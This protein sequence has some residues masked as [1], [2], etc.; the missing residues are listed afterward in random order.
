[1]FATRINVRRPAGIAFFFLLISLFAFAVTSKAWAQTPPSQPE[2]SAEVAGATVQQEQS[3]DIVGGR[4]AAPGAWPWQVALVSHNS[5][6][7]YYGQ[8]CGGSL[9]APDWVLTAAHCLEGT[10]AS[11][12]D[13]MVGVHRLTESWPR[14]QADRVL[15]HPDRSEFTLDGDVALLHLSMPVTQTTIALFTAGA[16][17]SELDYLRGTV[18]GWGNMDPNSWFGEF[19]DALQ[20]VAL[21]LIGWENCRQIWGDAISD[22]QICA[23]YPIMN[24]STCSGDSG[25]PLMV[26]KTNGQWLQVGIVEAGPYPCA[27]AEYPDIFTRISAYGSWIEGCMQNPDDITCTGADSY[28]PDDTAPA[29]HLY[30]SFGITETHSFHQA[31]DQDWLRFAVQAGHLYEI[32][33]Q[34]VVTSTVEVDTL[35]WLFTNEGRTPLAYN[36]DGISP[37]DEQPVDEQQTEDMAN[38]S[39]LRWRAGADGELYVSVENMASPFS[40]APAY[41]AHAK[42]AIAIVDYAHQSYLPSIEGGIKLTPTPTPTPIWEPPFAGEPTPAPVPNS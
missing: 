31:G 19:P 41:G 32:R 39:L 3:P 24:K 18:V 9:I 11:S 23:G 8:Y 17:G 33:T 4:E 25:G 2:P 1:M 7:A 26:Q 30:T 42:Y 28:E 12:V 38:D 36:N 27:G 13:V 6:N 29:A 14:I 37:V 22:K 10:P 34:H 20:E 15:L 40:A 21:P 5:S 35:I 16:D